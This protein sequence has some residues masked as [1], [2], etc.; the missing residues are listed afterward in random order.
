MLFAACRFEHGTAT[1]DAAEVVSDATPDSA[2]A[3][4]C[5]AADSSLVA[6][7]ELE[8]NGDDGSA[9]ML[10]AQVA[11]VEFAPGH[12][13]MAM[14]FGPASAA[15]VADS[16]ALDVTAITLEAWINPR[17]LPST[18]QRMGILDA[19]GQYGL[20]LHESGE[21]RCSASAA[22]QVLANIAVDTWTHVACTYEPPMV[23]IY[24]NG[25]GFPSV[26]NGGALSM[27]VNGLSIAADN[28]PGSGSRLIGLI[29]D[30]RL[31]SR[32]RSSDEICV[33]AGACPPPIQ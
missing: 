6:C 23:R 29:D 19:N 33:D 11:S 17:Q 28:P 18:G 21:L 12:R 1:T 20:F 13:G 27:G 3:P 26:T 25:V 15:D 22:S 24:V 30:V 5:D 7:Y 31:W 9:N 16:A 10:H 8:G 32:A 14:Q 4:F 2:L